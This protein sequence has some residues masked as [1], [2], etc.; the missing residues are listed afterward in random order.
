M[1]AL[2]G[3]HS[4][5]VDPEAHFHS[6]LGTNGIAQ[7]SL[8]DDVS[9]SHA[10]EE[11][12]GASIDLE[13]AY[14][15]VDWAFQQAVYGWA[16]L[17]YQAFARGFL[18][19]AGHSASRVVLYTDSVLEFWINGKPF[20]GGDF[21]SFRRAPL[22]LDLAPGANQIDLRLLR[23]VRSM[24][25]VGCPS[26][27]LRLSVQLCSA[28]LKVVENSAVLPDVING[29]LVSPYAS[30]I[31]RNETGEWI[32]VVGIDRKRVSAC[33]LVLLTSTH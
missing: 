18:T 24:G 29:K 27:S 33:V 4:L 5:P 16:A 19:V 13:V 9:I 28:A 12:N 23:D 21:Y 17:Q 2:G 22:V 6:S 31:A 25:G 32:T 8:I 1:E 7:W 30:I 20:F 14:P 11:D 15:E 10:G 3:F 26:I